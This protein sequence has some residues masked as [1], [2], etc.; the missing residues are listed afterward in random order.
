MS[1]LIK[2]M[3]MPPSCFLCKLSFMSGERLFC[4]AMKNEEVLR[5]KI[6]SNCPLI[7]IPP[8]GRL[9]DESWLKETLIE[10]LEAIR[11]NPKMD[12]QEMHLI[13]SFATLGE[14]VADAPTIIEAEGRE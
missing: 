8:H 7:E 11:K 3:K 10:T 12:M 4:S 9:I 1:I 6:D 13:A 2:G 14:M 5:S